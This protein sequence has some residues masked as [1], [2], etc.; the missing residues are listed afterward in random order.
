MAGKTVA[1]LGGGWGG[2]TAAHVLRMLLTEEHRVQ[3][4]SKSPTFSVPFS[5][6]WV[7]T[8]ERSHP[9]QGEHDIR[10]LSAKGIEVIINDVQAVDVQRQRVVTGSAELPYDYLLV[11]LGA[12]YAPETI[13]GFSEAAYNFYDSSEAHRLHS[14]LAE[15]KEGRVVV[16]I[17]RTP[18]KCPAAPYE[19]AFLVDALLAVQGVREIVEIALYTPE[20]QPMPVAGRVVGEALENMLQERRIA[21]HPKRTVQRIDAARKQIEFGD[22]DKTGFDLLIGVPPHVAPPAVRGL[23]G[24]AGWIPVS[25]D[26]M[27]TA[28]EGIFAIGDV[29]TIPL[30]HGLPLPKAGVFAAAQAEVAARN[31]AAAVRGQSASETFDGQGFCF[32][33]VADGL[34]AYGDG[35]FY[36]DPAP[37]IQ[38][39]PPSHEYFVRKRE[40][41]KNILGSLF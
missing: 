5:N 16:L 7:M 28:Q 20:P 34:A 31:I 17:T 33:E 35:N 40:W 21:Y 22:G 1:V 15:L 30:K 12:D 13:S 26:T 19:A 8:G 24:P 3:L 38:L 27:A 39:A 6:L 32:I 10:G 4:I 37:A 36:A 29:T 25:S 23:V 2:L 9:K 11:A 14:A 41:E 18:F